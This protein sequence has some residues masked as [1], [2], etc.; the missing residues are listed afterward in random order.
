MS[1]SKLNALLPV[2]AR[3]ELWA[4]SVEPVCGTYQAPQGTNFRREQESMCEFLKL[5]KMIYFISLR[6]FEVWLTLSNLRN[7]TIHPGLAL[8]SF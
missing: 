8:I 2:M 4:C 5:S 3:A 1:R 6:S 7:E